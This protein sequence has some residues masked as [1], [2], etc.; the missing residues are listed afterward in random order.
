MFRSPI[1][2]H[3]ALIFV[4]WYVLGLL[5]LGWTGGSAVAGRAALVSFVIL[6]VGACVGVW[7]GLGSEVLDRL[8]LEREIKKGDARGGAHVTFGKLPV[9]TKKEKTDA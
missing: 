9:V 1:F 7:V 6:L 3:A 8:M 4:W 2:K 5:V